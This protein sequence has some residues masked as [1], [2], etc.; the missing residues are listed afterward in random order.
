MEDCRSKST[1]DN[2]FQEQLDKLNLHQFVDFPT[3]RSGKLLDL[4]ISNCTDITVSTCTDLIY[5]S[6]HK[7]IKVHFKSS[8]NVFIHPQPVHN[9]NVNWKLL[10]TSPAGRKNS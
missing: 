4:V 2:C 5:T 9:L 10:N 1:S 8:Q 7:P 6:D 3:H